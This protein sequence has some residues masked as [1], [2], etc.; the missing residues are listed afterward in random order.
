MAELRDYAKSKGVQLVM[1]HETSGSTVNYERY[2]DRAYQ[3]MKDNNYSVVKSGY[4]GAIIP[5]GSHHYDQNTVNHFLHCIRRAADYEIMIDAHEPV[6]P[7]GL[8][9]TWPQLSCSR[10]RPRY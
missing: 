1:H 10:V 9:R 3:F 2:L 8:H 4:V 5:R 6:R 7:T